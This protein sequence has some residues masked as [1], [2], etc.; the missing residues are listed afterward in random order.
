MIHPTVRF[1]VQQE[2]EERTVSYTELPDWARN[3]ISS[4]AD[5]GEGTIIHKDVHV[6]EEVRIGKNCQIQGQ[7]Y[8][9]N[10]VTLGD[11]VFVGP[12]TVFTNDPTMQGSRYLFEPVPIVVGNGVKIGANCSILAGVKMG[13]YSILG[14]GSVLRDDLPPGEVWAG[15]AQARFVRRT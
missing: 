14:M 12:G 4:K 7:V 5:I 3:A 13:D 8:L 9:P 15:M 11:D 1:W 2:G 6:H 10:G